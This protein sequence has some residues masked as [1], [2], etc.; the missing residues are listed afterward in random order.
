MQIETRTGHLLV[1]I[2]TVLLENPPLTYVHTCAYKRMNTHEH[3]P[4]RDKHT[5]TVEW[6]RRRLIDYGYFL[7]T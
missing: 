4:H 6:L 5:C 7:R 1:L 3:T 2:Y